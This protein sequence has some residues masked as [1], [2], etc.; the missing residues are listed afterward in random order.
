MGC[1]G[2]IDFIA[3]L[4]LTREAV[5]AGFQTFKLTL[6][7]LKGGHSGVHNRLVVGFVLYA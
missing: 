6:K 5:P 7:G 4:P 1:A 3:T 2:G